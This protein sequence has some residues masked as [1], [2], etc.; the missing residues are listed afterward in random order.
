MTEKQKLAAEKYRERNKAIMDAAVQSV[1]KMMETR[2]T[3]EEARA[4]QQQLKAERLRAQ[5]RE[6]ANRLFFLQRFCP[7]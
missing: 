6:E 2:S 7:N 3:M 1:K 4:S 5:K